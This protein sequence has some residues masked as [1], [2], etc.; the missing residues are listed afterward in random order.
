M[1]IQSRWPS[2]SYAGISIALM[3]LMVPKQQENRVNVSSVLQLNLLRPKFDCGLCGGIQANEEIE[4][5]FEL[6]Q[7]KWDW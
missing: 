2:A 1:T 6:E 7:P 4:K 5:A 3:D